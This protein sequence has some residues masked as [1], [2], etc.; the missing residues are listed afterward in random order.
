MKTEL[1]EGVKEREKDLASFILNKSYERINY[2]ESDGILTY[3]VLE[4]GSRVKI[5]LFLHQLEKVLSPKVFYRCGW[6]FIVNLTKIHEYWVLEYP[7]LVME[8]GEI[9][10]VPQ[11][12]KDAISGLISRELIMRKD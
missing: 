9:I 5:D 8:N 3:I 2:F 6:S 11:S 10:P 4:D 12:E 1:L 7:F